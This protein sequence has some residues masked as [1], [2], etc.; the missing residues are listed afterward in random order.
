MIQ[1][2]A[3]SKKDID[4]KTIAELTLKCLKMSVPS[5]VPNCFCSG[6]QSEFDAAKNL[7]SINL[8]NDTNFT[9]TY[10]YGRALQKVLWNFRQRTQNIK[11]RRKCLITEQNVL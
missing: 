10:S 6:G 2:W 9:M 3:G 11:V 4:A 8:I 5:E 7:N 1:L